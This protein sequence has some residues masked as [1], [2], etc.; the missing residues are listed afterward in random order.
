M[1]EED[2]QGVATTHFEAAIDNRKAWLHD[3]G[4][5]GWSAASVERFLAQ[6]GGFV[7]VET[8]IDAWVDR[9]G[10]ARRVVSRDRSWSAAADGTQEEWATNTTTTEFF[11][12]GIR[13]DIWPP[14]ESEV[15]E[16]DELPVRQE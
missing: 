11:D 14:A 9:D 3:L 6:Q 2:V 12:F 4:Q 16:W 15:V 10:R 7:D 8:T 13:V 1:G 5:L